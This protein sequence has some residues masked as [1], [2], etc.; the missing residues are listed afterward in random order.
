MAVDELL[1]IIPSTSAGRK[2]TPNAIAIPITTT[3]VTTTCAPPSPR[4][5]PRIVQGTEGAKL[6]PDEEQHHDHAELGEVHDVVAFMTHQMQ[7]GG[8]D[9]DAG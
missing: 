9:G 2:C 4:I 6:E 3:V 1:A 7:A 5:G 8:A